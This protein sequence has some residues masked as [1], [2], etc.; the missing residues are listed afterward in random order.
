MSTYV[1]VQCSAEESVT[2]F[3]KN[4]A[5]ELS[6]NEPHSLV[7]SLTVFYMITKFVLKLKSNVMKVMSFYAVKVRGSAEESVTLLFKNC[8]DKLSRNRSQSLVVSPYM[9]P[10]FVFKLKNIRC[11]CPS[12]QLRPIQNQLNPS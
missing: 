8:A 5:D 10:K 6:R 4:C 9:I 12:N 1:K 3:L 7:I 2:L 11:K